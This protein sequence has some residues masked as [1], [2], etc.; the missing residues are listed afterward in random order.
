[1]MSRARRS[2]LILVATALA[3]GWSAAPIALAAEPAAKSEFDA[4]ER[5]LAKLVN[6]ARKEKKVPPFDFSDGLSDAARNHSLE[7]AADNIPVG[8]EGFGARQALAF[9]LHGANHT[10]E[11][12]TSNTEPPDAAAAKA[13]EKWM[14]S[15]DHRAHLLGEY[16]WAGVGVARSA[17]GTFY[18]TLLVAGPWPLTGQ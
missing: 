3:L 8:H 11:N 1:M 15:K 2:T 7:M 17:A 6:D 14:K 10:A 12:V 16:Y 18:F 5:E 13:V 9:R 4:I